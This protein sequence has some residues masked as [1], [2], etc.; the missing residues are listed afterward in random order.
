MLSFLFRFRVLC[1]LLT[2]YCLLPTDYCL[3]P[4]ATP[5]R[6][7]DP[8]NLR[9]WEVQKDP[10]NRTESG[11]PLRCHTSSAVRRFLYDPWR[12]STVYTAKSGLPTGIA[13][14]DCPNLQV[15]VP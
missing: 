8:E 11:I 7:R 5:L 12:R 15:Q 14:R 4:T 2:A 9:C 13:R 1:L 6:P 3:L 10:S